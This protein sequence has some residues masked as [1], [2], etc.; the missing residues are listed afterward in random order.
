M[1]LRA[2]I[3][4]ISTFITRETLKP[5]CRQLSYSTD[6]DRDNNDV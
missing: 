5:F 3:V 2:S 4:Y 1:V 6:G